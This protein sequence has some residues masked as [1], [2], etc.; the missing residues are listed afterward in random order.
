VETK[1]RKLY[2]TAQQYDE[3]FPVKLFYGKSAIEYALGMKSIIESQ[4]TKITHSGMESDVDFIILNDA[5][6]IVKPKQD[7]KTIEI[8]FCENFLTSQGTSKNVAIFSIS[9]MRFKEPVVCVTCCPNVA[10]VN[11]SPYKYMMRPDSFV[12][13]PEQVAE[14]FKFS[15]AKIIVS[16]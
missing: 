14:F 3:Q 1:Y 11:R 4:D 2:M 15:T 8:T 7:G 9:I 12:V 6:L 13:Q 16:L 10:I 5:S